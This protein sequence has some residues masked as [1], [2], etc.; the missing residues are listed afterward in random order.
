MK[1]YFITAVLVLTFLSV[2]IVP[3][4]AKEVGYLDMTIG[5]WGQFCCYINGQPN[6]LEPG[7]E[8]HVEADFQ[9]FGTAGGIDPSYGFMLFDVGLNPVW[10]A[11][12]QDPTEYAQGKIHRIALDVT[13]DAA[14][15]SVGVY[16]NIT[17]NNTGGGDFVVRL[18]DTISGYIVRNGEKLTL[19][20]YFDLGDANF[21]WINGGTRGTETWADT[22]TSSPPKSPATGDT[23]MIVAAF[24]LLTLAGPAFIVVKK[25]RV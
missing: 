6:G 10:A 16:F 15:A 4:A 8:L 17:N 9:F 12:H 11:S 25:A 18:Y 22:G 7:D 20:I 23:G 1:K 21:L 19:D 2:L 24:L 14:W 3:A 13:Y 5:T